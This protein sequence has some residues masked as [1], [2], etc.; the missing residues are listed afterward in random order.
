VGAG[1]NYWVKSLTE[2]GHEDKGY[3]PNGYKVLMITSRVATANAQA[4]KLEADTRFDFK[5][6][7]NDDD[8]WGDEPPVQKV[9][10]CTNSY[11]EW[12]AKNLYDPNDPKTHVWNM[13]DFI[14]LDEAHSMTSDATFSESPFHVQAFLR[15][16][17]RNSKKCRIIMMSGTPEAITWL[18]EG[19][20]S[21]K[22]VKVI[23]LYKKCRHLEPKCVTIRALDGLSERIIEKL[24]QGKRIIY[25]A[26]TS[27]NMQCLV[28]DLKNGGIPLSDIGISYS[29][30]P[31]KDEKFDGELVDKRKCIF[32]SLSKRE[33]LPADIKIL[34]STSKNKEGININD[35]DIKDMIVESHQRDEVRQMA[36]RIREG[37]DN[38]VI[39][40]DA[41]QHSSSGNSL[42]AAI[43]KKSIASINKAVEM[44]WNK[45]KHKGRAEKADDISEV[46]KRHRYVRYDHFAECFRFYRGRDKGDALARSDDTCFRS[47]IAA[48]KEANYTGD[49][50]GYDNLAAWF[51]DARTLIYPPCDLREAVVNL[52]NKE[53]VL[54]KQITKAERDILAEKIR[55]LIKTHS[56]SGTDIS[57]KFKSLAPVLTKLGYRLDEVEGVRKGSL[58]VIKEI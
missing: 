51:P 41:K 40:G 20:T 13:F 38:L 32:E 43:D 35:P 57:V 46:E 31:K 24:L 58:Y 17:Y 48:C 10:C 4:I 23:N 2:K 47:D 15:H 3:A 22:S 27:D 37:L 6:L 25:F 33:V 16:A 42:F 54:N 14:V 44:F 49:F 56:Q 29:D 50:S 55:N 36:G 5:R 9:V 53:D 8:W 11:I 30:D 1:K 45:S 21:Q 39:I 19:V 12:Y 26:T 34:I 52:F 7:I 28:E 18:Y